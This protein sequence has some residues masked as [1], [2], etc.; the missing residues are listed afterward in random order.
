MVVAVGCGARC[1]G[2]LVWQGEANERWPRALLFAWGFFCVALLPILGFIDVGFMQYSLVA[3]HYLH[4]ALIGVVAAVAA[5]LWIWRDRARKANRS[6][7]NVV[8]VALVG[9]LTLLTFQQSRLYGDPIKLYEATLRDNPDCWAAHNNLGVLLLD[10][11]QLEAAKLHFEQ[12]LRLESNY[13][14]SALRS[15]QLSGENGP[16]DAGD[17]T[18]SG[19]GAHSARLC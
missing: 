2:L 15:G 8:A 13:P 4:I 17:R 3:D 10:S 1:D 7:A 11:R 5:G 16:A 14:E 19:S 9:I 18:I 12:A 6:A